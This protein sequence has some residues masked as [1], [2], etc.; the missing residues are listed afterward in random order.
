MQKK[1]EKKVIK[2][3]TKKTKAMVYIGK[4]DRIPVVSDKMKQVILL[5]T[6]TPKKYIKKRKGRAGMVYDYVE[7]NYV[8]GRL[9]A[10][11]LYNWRA[12][13]IWHSIDK[14]INQVI[15]K[16]KLTARF[17]DGT[18]VVKEAFGGAD[19]QRNKATGKV[20]DLAD[21]LKSAESDALKKASSMLGIAWDVYAGLT[22]TKK[23]SPEPASNVHKGDV[24]N[25]PQDYN[26]VPPS[27]L[28][29]ENPTEEKERMD[30][31]KK[32]LIETI[33]AAITKINNFDYKDFK[34]FLWDFQKTRTPVRHFVGKKF[35][36]VSLSEGRKDDLWV[37][38]KNM[39]WVIQRYREERGD[40]FRILELEGENAKNK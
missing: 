18:E 37:M 5:S 34:N 2:K 9:N 1:E 4:D 26:I 16:I 38:A 8:I 20:I 19:I 6:I 17:A 14:E 27:H 33:R 39:D 3:G 12:E 31:E 40:E 21:C 13:V 30:D 28:I 15:V 7:T 11:F 23:S 25:Y 35:G 10:T 36:N 24:E 29:T 32:E 22:T